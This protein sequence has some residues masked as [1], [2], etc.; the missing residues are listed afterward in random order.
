VNARRFKPDDTVDFV[1]V[2]SGA[3]GGVMARELA[4]AGF[5]ALLNNPETSPQTSVHLRRIELRHLGPRP[6]D[7]DHPGA[8]LPCRRAHRAVCEA[9]RDLV[10]RYS[11]STTAALEHCVSIAR[12][13]R[14]LPTEMVRFQV[15]SRRVAPAQ[16]VPCFLAPSGE[17]GFERAALPGDSGRGEAVLLRL[18][19]ARRE[20]GDHGLRATESR[21][22]RSLGRTRAASEARGDQHGGYRDWPGH[23]A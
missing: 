21:G 20:R 8:R 16:R 23:A 2:G 6:V 5:D 22:R 11:E 19:E 17:P 7:H 1:V 9:R 15:L 14:A 18:G 12:L 3:D 4:Q 13:R 10:A